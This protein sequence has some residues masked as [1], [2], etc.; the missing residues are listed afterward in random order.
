MVPVPPEGADHGMVIVDFSLLVVCVTEP[1]NH[2]Y[3]YSAYPCN[4]LNLNVVKYLRAESPIRPYFLTQ[5]RPVFPQENFFKWV[6]NLIVT[7]IL[8]FLG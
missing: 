7:L 2:S 5:S 8:C 1:C 4:K 3:V 6:K